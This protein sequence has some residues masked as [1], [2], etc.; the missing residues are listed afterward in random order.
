MS[1]YIKSEN[2]K[3]K[4]SY[5]AYALIAVVAASATLTANANTTRN[6][7]G[8]TGTADAPKNLWDYANWDGEGDFYNG[9]TVDCF[10][11]VTDTT[12]LNSANGA[13][14]FCCDLVPNSGDFVFMGLLQFYCLKQGS[15]ENS[16][17]SIV[18]KRAIGQS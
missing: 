10:L 12:Y 1:K 5:V 6:W 4:V 11:S 8:G 3:F 9:N 16:T 15:V 14:R 18:K 17:V 2:V 13:N 7:I